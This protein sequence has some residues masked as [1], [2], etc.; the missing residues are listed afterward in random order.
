[1]GRLY[2]EIYNNY[3]NC[4]EQ[5]NPARRARRNSR[6]RRSRRS[7]CLIGA[8]HDYSP[9]LEKLLQKGKGGGPKQRRILELNPSHDILGKLRER[10]DQDQNDPAIEDYAHLLFGYGLIAESSELED[11]VRFNKAMADLMSKSL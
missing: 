7:R 10:F 8:E 5:R 2:D 11:P 9:Q 3:R 1:M 4:S 6:R